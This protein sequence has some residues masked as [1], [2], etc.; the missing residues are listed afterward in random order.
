MQSTI[1]PS[2]NRTAA[3]HSTAALAVWLSIQLLVLVASATGL[4]WSANSVVPGDLDAFR[5]MLVAQVTLASLFSQVLCSTPTKA[6]LS[7]LLTWPFIAAAAYLS[8]THASIMVLSGLYLTGWIWTL[9]LLH[10]IRAPLPTTLPAFVALLVLGGP[11]LAYLQVEF[12][13]RESIKFG[14][15]FDILAL[16]AGQ[17]TPWNILLLIALNVGALL[18]RSPKR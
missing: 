7:A 14:P 9:G 4:R 10:Q 11:L 6:I 16:A 2:T 1:T 5:V 15:I 18:L 3:S 13:G 17:V 12:S 8:A